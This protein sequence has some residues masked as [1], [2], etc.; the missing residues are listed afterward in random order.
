MQRRQERKAPRHKI[1]PDTAFTG[2]RGVTL[3]KDIILSMGYSWHPTTGGLE[4]GI[5]GIIELRDPTT[6]Q[7]LNQVIQVQSKALSSLPG[8]TT[9]S[10]T[11]PC[12]ERDLTYWLQGNAPVIL[13]VS[14]PASREAYW[15]S[16]KDYFRDL[17]LQTS[18]TVHF[19]K[20]RDRLDATS[21]DRL[22]DLAVPRDAGLYL[23]PAPKREQL[24]T[25]L[26]RIDLP[27]R[28]YIGSTD[29]R[30]PWQVYDITKRLGV[31][32][33]P[34]W[35]LTKK[36]ILSFYNLGEYPWTHVCD[37]GTVE[38]H[39]TAEWSDT[40]DQDRRNELTA[41][42]NQTVRGKLHHANVEYHDRYE[43][44]YALPTKD[45]TTRS[46]RYRSLTRE[47]RRA[48]FQG[49]PSKK[50]PKTISYYRHAALQTQLFQFH[51]TWYL[52]LT[53]TYH[54]TRDGYRVS[55]YREEQLKGIKR[56]E[57]NGAVLGQVLMWTSILTRAPNLFITSQA[58][59]SFGHP[60][61]LEVNCGLV[62]KTWLPKEPGDARTV[63]DM[64]DNNPRLY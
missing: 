23:A 55:P 56:L 33:G 15:V 11:Y 38:E 4:V 18:R 29:Q 22:R 44:F 9:D 46:I 32:I 34:E 21:R 52:A 6:G 50:D 35:Y 64:E 37:Q 61:Q 16:I 43:Y 26:L 8:E 51:T 24:Y 30:K 12:G 2:E 57:R 41:L 25:N 62:D 40:Q 39:E 5:D 3:I 47:V 1:I 59:L 27:S 14:K 36:L 53:P 17:T 54:Y 28:L 49:Y 20:T 42:L 13:V 19:N 10:F 48:I 63:I 31:H 7:A 58:H 45:L 60:S